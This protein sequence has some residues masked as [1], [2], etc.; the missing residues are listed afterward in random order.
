MK[1]LEPNR[2]LLNFPEDVTTAANTTAANIK[3]TNTVIIFLPFKLINL[4]YLNRPLT[5][6]NTFQYLYPF[7][8]L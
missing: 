1:V 2:F 7:Y 8:L 4:F 3:I 5:R 6:P